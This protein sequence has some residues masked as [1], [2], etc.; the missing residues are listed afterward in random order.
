[1]NNTNKQ[2]GFALIFSVIIASILLSV[3]LAMFSIALK[4]LI[5]SSSGRNS[6]FAFYAA[7]SAIECALYWDIRHPGFGES[8]FASSSDS[9]ILPKGSNV[10]CNEEDITLTESGWDPGSGWDISD[11]SSTGATTVFDMKFTNDYCAT[12]SV[13]KSNGNTRIDSRGYNTCDLG[14]PR[15]VERG[16]RVRY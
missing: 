15:R 10:F 13:I 14:N 5:L 9:T 16:L 12:V 4:E 11:V 7:D 8:V 3:G 6:Q 2:K 1:M